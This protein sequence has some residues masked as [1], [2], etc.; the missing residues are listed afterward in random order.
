[1]TMIDCNTHD[2]SPIEPYEH[3]WR[4]PASWGM[5]SVH[6]VHGTPN[7][8]GTCR[9]F[10]RVVYRHIRVKQ[11]GYPEVVVRVEVPE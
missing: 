3:L 4:P 5:P 10:S 7:S 9:I 1:M 8:E 6:E 11:S 2:V